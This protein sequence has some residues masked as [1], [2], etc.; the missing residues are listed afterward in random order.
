M[1]PERRLASS[2]AQ[3]EQIQVR[4]NEQEELKSI[5]QSKD[6]CPLEVRG[7]SENKYGKV[8]I[9][10]AL[11]AQFSEATD[12]GR[13]Q[14]HISRVY[15]EDFALVSDTAYVAQNAARITRALLEI[16]LS[17]NWAQT[18]RLLIDLSKA[19]E[20]RMWPYENPLTQVTTLQRETLYNLSQWADDYEPSQLRQMEVKEIGDLIHMNEKHGLAVR[21]AAAALPT[22]LLTYEMRPLS[23]DLLRILV[24][25]KADF[26][27]SSKLSGQSEPFYV[28]IQDEEGLSILQSRSILLRPSTTVLQLDF[29]IPFAQKVDTLGLVAVSDR[30][31]GVDETMEVDLRALTMPPESMN[32][33]EL[34]DIAFL[35]ISALDDRDLEAR[36][37]PFITTLNGMQSQAFWSVYHTQ[38]NVLISAPIG[39]GKSFLGEVA[40]WYVVT[41]TTRLYADAYR[42]AFKHRPEAKVLFLVPGMPKVNTTV[43]RL[44]SVCPPGR[45]IKIEP[46]TSP[47][48][49]DSIENGSSGLVT[50]ASGSM[51]NRLAPSAFRRMIQSCDVIIL[52]DL[53][54]LDVEAELAIATSLPTASSARVRIVGL[55]SSLIG[56]DDVATWLGVQDDHRYIFLPR[57]RGIP[58]AVSLRTFTIPHSSTLLKTMIKPVYDTLKVA[59]GSCIVF[60]P[61][62]SACRVVA[63]DLVTQSGTEMDLNGFL[64]APR[65][66]VE[67]YTQRLRDYRLHEPCLHGIGYLHDNTHPSDL[68][69]I[70]E[71]YAS[72]ILKILI[73]PRE[74]CWTLPVR[75]ATVVVMGAQYVETRNGERQVLNY[76]FEDLVRMQGYASPSANPIASDANP[77]GGKMHVLCQAEQR[78]AISR[79]LYDGLPLESQIPS[80]LRLE[81]SPESIKALE[82]LIKAR[83]QGT[84]SANRPEAKDLRKRDMMDFLAWTYFF[85]RAK[86]NPAYYGLEAGDQA[87]ISRM[88]DRW[89]AEADRVISHP[90]PQH[91]VGT[92]M[93][94][95]MEPK[96][97]DADG[98][99]ME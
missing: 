93:I 88:I 65:S 29:V 42:H 37:R 25:V 87:G 33:T 47:S 99:S 85:H 5:M 54:I 97:G 19:I 72:G 74:A 16:A 32:H 24:K 62:R 30:W 13:L 73:C 98:E 75:A 18:S 91:G 23:H 77:Q 95:P 9:L 36:Y 48:L 86:T 41:N 21:D 90:R 1:S 45:N 4:E 38:R 76:P 79:I 51:L 96:I 64:M 50:V 7:G 27:W 12:C 81:T 17:R 8:N 40:T 53:H 52:D 6:H 61:S 71:L 69:V 20:R 11:H 44:R 28:W 94:D 2:L 59:S 10:C 63:D 49:L 84:N 66:D 39:S 67:P 35:H 15:I 82:R 22:P 46:F 92:P 80:L 57:D 89:F 70:L 3:F 55:T 83:L 34:L 78:L 14:A 43:Q 56:S 26:T 60:V 68:A 31:F 58:I